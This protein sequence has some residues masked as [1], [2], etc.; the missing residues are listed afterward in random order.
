MRYYAYKQIYNWI[1][2]KTTAIPSFVKIIFYLSI[3]VVLISISA[4]IALVCATLAKQL[5]GLG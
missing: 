5:L 1:N 3:S 2:Q 4:T